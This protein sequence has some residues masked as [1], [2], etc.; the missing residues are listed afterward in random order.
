MSISLD[1]GTFELISVILTYM[2]GLIVLKSIKA[3]KGDKN[4]A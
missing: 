1:I 4:E 2:A 3:Y